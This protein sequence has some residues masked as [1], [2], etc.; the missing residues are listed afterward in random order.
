MPTTA[1]QEKEVVSKY[2]P[3]PL[4]LEIHKAIY[5]NGKRKR[6]VCLAIHRRFGK[7]VLAVNELVG[8]ALTSPKDPPV[9]CIYVAPTFMQ[10]KNI[11]WQPLKD[12]TRMISK[13]VYKESELS[14]TF[15]NGA[16]IKLWGAENYDNMRGQYC[17][18]VV[19]DE[20]GNMSENVWTEVLRPALSDRKGWAI[21]LGTPNGK[22]HFYKTYQEALG[23]PSWLARTYRADQTQVIDD[24]ELADCLKKM[25]ANKYRQEYLCDWSAAVLGTYYANELAVIKER[26]QITRVP[27]TQLLPVI[28]VFD[29]GLD[30]YMAVWFVQFYGKEIRVL[31]YAQWTNLGLL[32]VLDEIERTKRNYSIKELW[33]PHDIAVRELTTG[34]SRLESLEERGYE[35]VVAKRSDVG[36]GIN[37]VR[38]LLSQCW[39]DKV[40]TERGLDCLENYRKKM[41]R[42]T[43]VFSERPEHD[44]Y[45]H[46]A[47]AFRTLAML[48]HE[49]LGSPDPARSFNF[50]HKAQRYNAN[51]RRVVRSV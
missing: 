16:E 11:A 13:M 49:E 45:S 28:A 34:R 18:A 32:D 40:N 20:W 50:K 23:D 48:Y 46:G 4:Q 1:I 7:T 22:N 33:L 29:L 47:D 27:H 14:A 21:F 42:A 6:F 2:I 10:A 9:K 35:C 44:E 39:F 19:M 26:G 43:G 15:P 12:A 41:D 36:D 3:R 31:D 30:D 8:R 51:N 17:D 5:N 24:A 37:S 38:A 25:G